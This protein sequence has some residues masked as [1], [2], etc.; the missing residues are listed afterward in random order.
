MASDETWSKLR[1]FKKNSKIDKWGDSEL[2]QD[3]HL[4]RLDDFRDYIGCPIYVTR[5]VQTSGHSKNSYHYSR[6]DDHGRQIGACA[7][8][9]VIPDYGE[10]PFDLILDCLRFGFTGLGYYPAWKFRGHVVGGLHVDSRPLIWQADKTLN[11]A[12]SRWM[13]IPDGNGGQRYIELNWHNLAKYSQYV[14]DDLDD[15]NGLH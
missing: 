1:Y 7:T 4:L 5:G 14:G 12:H 10:S 15:G 3:D 13:G 6:H 8:D 2:I 11:Y 9:I